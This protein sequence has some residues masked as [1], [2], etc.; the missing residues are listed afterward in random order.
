MNPRQDQPN[1]PVPF[2]TTTPTRDLARAHSTNQSASVGSDITCATAPAR[3][4]EPPD[5]KPA[6]VVPLPLE[7]H[8]PS[9][10][11]HDL[12]E[13]DIFQVQLQVDVAHERMILYRAVVVLEGLGLLLLLRQWLL[14]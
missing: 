14:G 5:S 6:V 3:W 10:E 2:A 11:I 1:A 12:S 9:A 13:R 7:P 8:Q 4:R